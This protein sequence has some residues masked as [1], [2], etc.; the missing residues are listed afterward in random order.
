LADDTIA[1]TVIS[2]E[3]KMRKIDIVLL[4]LVGQISRGLCRHGFWPPWKVRS[5]E[6]RK[7]RSCNS[8]ALIVRHEDDL[9]MRRQSPD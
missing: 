8:V 1:P 4:E 7:L 5:N 3:M 6:W 9:K 2:A